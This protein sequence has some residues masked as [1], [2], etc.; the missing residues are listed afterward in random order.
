[1][2]LPFPWLGIEVTYGPLIRYGDSI[3]HG[4]VAAFD[5]L[6]IL[7]VFLPLQLATALGLGFLLARTL[8]G[9]ARA[10]GALKRRIANINSL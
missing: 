8:K 2:G 3:A 1:M 10:G 5:G 4:P 9:L 7:W 6:D